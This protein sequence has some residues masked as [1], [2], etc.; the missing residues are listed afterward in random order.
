MLGNFSFGDY[1]KEDA[2]AFAGSFNL[3]QMASFAQRKADGHCHAED[4][5]AYDIWHKKKWACL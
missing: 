3:G 5:E 4:D 1:F 2:I